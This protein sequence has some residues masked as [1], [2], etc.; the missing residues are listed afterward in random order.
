MTPADVGPDDGDSPSGL[1]LHDG[2]SCVPA[3]RR[4]RSDHKDKG[5]LESEPPAAFGGRAAPTPAAR[6]ESAEP[7]APAPPAPPAASAPPGRP[8]APDA[9]AGRAGPVG[10]AG[11][12]DEDLVEAYG[13]FAGDP[14]LVRRSLADRPPAPGSRGQGSVG[15]VPPPHRGPPGRRR[16]RDRG[17]PTRADAQSLG[18]HPRRTLPLP[19]MLGGREVLGPRRRPTVAHRPDHHREPHVPVPATPPDQQRPGWRVRLAVDGTAT[20]TDPVGRQRVTWPRDHLDR[21]TLLADPAPAAAACPKMPAGTPKPTDAAH[22]GCRRNLEPGA[23]RE[24]PPRR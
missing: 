13:P 3:D 5:P 2:G 17:I 11:S 12:L 22:D 16:H 4:G 15:S 20:W 10:L 6:R 24:T 1:N 14:M 8:A 21:L 7:A 9:P 23:R 18:P 19:R